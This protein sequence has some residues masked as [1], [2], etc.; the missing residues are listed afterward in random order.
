MLKLFLL[1]DNFFAC[2]VIALLGVV[3]IMLAFNSLGAYYSEFF[4]TVYTIMADFFFC[5][6]IYRVL[7]KYA[8]WRNWQIILSKLCLVGL[9]A[10]CI[11]LAGKFILSES[12]PGVIK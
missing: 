6:G 7:C 8:Q 5:I 1:I 4:A 12:T 2:W 3:G 11:D 10:I 9:M